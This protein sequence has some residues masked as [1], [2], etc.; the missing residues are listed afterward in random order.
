MGRPGGRWFSNGDWDDGVLNKDTAR[1]NWE[2][3]HI[4]RYLEHKNTAK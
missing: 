2:K 4:Q 3:T 1:G